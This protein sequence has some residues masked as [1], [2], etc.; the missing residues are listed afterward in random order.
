[1]RWPALA[2]KV[3]L[4]IAA[5]CLAHGNLVIN[6]DFELGNVGFETSYLYSPTDV[7]AAGTYAVNTNPRNVHPGFES[8]GDRTSGL[9]N[10]MIVNGHETAGIVLWQQS[11]PVSPNT[12]Y[13]LSF[14]LSNC[15]SYPHRAEIE[16]SI[17]G[18]RLGSKVAPEE[19]GQWVQASEIWHSAGTMA[20]IKLVNLQKKPGGNDFAID[21]V[22]LTPV[23]D[24][25]VQLVVLSSPSPSDMTQ[26]LPVSLDCV[27]VGQD[28]YIELWASDVGSTNTRLTSVYVDMIIAPR[29]AVSVESI[30]H[31]GIFTLTTSGTADPCGI[32]E[33]GGSS[34]VGAGTEPNWARIAIVRLKAI[35]EGTATCSLAESGTGIAALTRGLIP[36]AAV[37]LGQV[38]LNATSMPAITEHPQDV[39]AL[40]GQDAAFTITASGS[41]P[42]H[43]LWKKNGSPIGEDSPTLVLQKVQLSDNASE[44]TC[45]V[46][47]IYGAVTSNP[48]ALNVSG[49][50][51]EIISDA[52]L[53]GNAGQLYSYDVNA[54]GVPEPTYSLE[55]SPE[56][57]DINPTT[58]LITW[59]PTAGQLGLNTITVKATNSEGVDEQSFTVE[60]FCQLVHVPDVV[61]LS[62]LDAEE[63]VIAAGL[64]IGGKTLSYHATLEPNKV[65]DQDPNG[66]DTACVGSPVYVVV[67]LGPPPQL[68]VDANSPNDPGYGTQQD[69]FRHIQDAIFAA[70]EGTKVVVLPGTYHENLSIS[71]SVILTSVDPND[72]NVV[73][74][75]IIN[76]SN[77]ADPN[78]GAAVTFAGGED[79]N[80]VITGFTITGGT[81][82]YLE[83]WPGF[84]SR[85]GGG[86]C[87]EPNASPTIT[88][89]VIT[90]NTAR[91]GGGNIWC[92]QNSQA[93]IIGNTI[94]NGQSLGEPGATASGGG[95]CCENAG[96]TATQ[97]PRIEHNIIRYNTAEGGAAIACG[98]GA[99]AIIRGN[100]IYANQ[101][102]DTGAIRLYRNQTSILNNTIVCNS[103]PVAAAISCHLENRS[104]I[105]NNII[106]FN[107]GG[108]ALSAFDDTD[109]PI[110]TYNDVWANEGGDF[111]G[112]VN[113]TDPNWMGNIF[114]DP[115]FVNM[116]SWDFHLLSSDSPC[117]DAGDP[118]YVPE[119]NETDLDGN[120][121]IVRAASDMGA[122]EYITPIELSQDVF[123]F[124]AVEDYPNPDAQILLVR[125]AGLGTLDWQIAG[126]CDWLTVDP[127]SGSSAGEDDTVWLRVD[128]AGL[129]PGDYN[130]TLTVSA[131]FAPSGTI[132]VSLVVQPNCFPKG[133]EYARQYADFLE[134]AA[135]GKSA[136]CWCQPYQCEGDADGRDSGPPFEV[137]VFTGDLAKIIYN[138]K[139]KIDEPTLDP[140]ADLDHRDSGIPFRFRVFTGDLTLLITNWKK[141]DADLRGNCPRPDPPPPDMV[142]IPGG[143]F[144]MGDNLNDGYSYERPVHTVTVH[145]FY[146]GKCEI[147]NGQ[148]CNYLNSAL[149]QGLL[150]VTSGVVYGAGSEMS[151]PYCDT[152]GAD[153]DSQID[154]L[155]GL[156]SVRTKSGRDMSD[157]P[158]VEVSWYGSAA[159]CN[160]RSQKEGKEQCYNLSTWNCA[161]SRNGYRLLTEAEWEYAARGGLPGRR[162]PWGD[163]IYH[164]QA[165]Y[166]S[167][168]SYS[169][170]RGPTGG[171]HPLWNDGIWPC[172]SP[173]GF[174]D[175]TMK[176]KAD[177]QWPGSAT[178]YQ[179]KSG[180]NNYGL[181]DMAGN[182]WEWCNDWYDSGYY[183]VSPTDNPTGP[184]TGSYR[185]LRGGS[186]YGTADYC[187]VANRSV[188]APTDRSSGVGFRVV[189]DLE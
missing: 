61:G 160:W 185:V 41:E 69:P 164:T 96:G 44:I 126:D 177:Y 104:L 93:R 10:M 152:H 159:Y 108:P 4:L 33:L 12:D 142:L 127:N 50:A 48:A 86:I 135:H 14:W 30:E 82:N 45:E 71:K 173:V 175:G 182:V 76:G 94:E 68:Y 143:T 144:Q 163:Y 180:A 138:W 59:T 77:P 40:L 119:P 18:I 23:S 63:A 83:G 158:M 161:F 15:L 43:Y 28:C 151:Y 2:I 21:E 26:T 166:H 128:T 72:P 141:E 156:F 168:T 132:E 49:I 39:F 57:M 55:T 187:R 99:N 165:N 65:I 125:N 31:G 121:R 183:S 22:N 36:W 11:V 178:S 103:A 111:G 112:A 134:Y 181:Y 157:D 81:G 60:V 34:V 117:V 113:P 25:T 19:T 91:C 145:S 70:S 66:G 155:G 27:P 150:T 147:T 1:M 56:G 17:N 179:T 115:L 106:A 67:S 16:Y 139:K 32:D 130:R 13:R 52:N 170:D 171:Y 46:S 109:R 120:P 38:T 9:G 8:Y 29:A 85:W 79:P 124:E 146:M 186:W 167:S 174:F 172:T 162:F 47:N 53:I 122:Y 149:T 97:G 84:W 118:N 80:C 54:T 114:A 51:P 73:A 189:L 107:T 64:E 110:V 188:S 95:I 102:T 6:G 75:T 7:T 148:Y 101:G 169:Y 5:N 116:T 42:L 105:S 35:A 24:V 37:D 58:G 74:E 87:V 184:T 136:D 123:E 140:C 153:S 88:A 154:Y 3:T 133:P 131:P 137:R 98:T 176:H 62:D 78:C 92:G 129:A 20:T 90:G 89:N 100:V